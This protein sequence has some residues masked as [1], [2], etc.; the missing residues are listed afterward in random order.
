MTDPPT[1]SSVPAGRRHRWFVLGAIVAVLALAHPVVADELDGARAQKEAVRERAV[2]AAERLRTLNAKDDELRRGLEDLDQAIE[3][4]Q[5]KVDG[6]EQ[7][8]ASAQR[9][10]VK[11]QQDL[12]AT[13]L[14]LE[15]ARS[16]STDAVL[17]AYIGAASGV[18]SAA[19]WFDAADLGEAVQ[20]QQ[21]LG[22]VRGRLSQ[23]LDSLRVLSQDQDRA[24]RDAERA[25]LEVSQWRKEL[26][27]AQA[28]LDNNRAVQADLEEQLRGEIT[29]WAAKRDA[30]AASEA[31]IDEIIRRKTAEIAGRAVPRPSAAIQVASAGG[32]SSASRGNGT[33]SSSRSGY[34]WP[35]DGPLTSNF[36]YRR[37]PITGDVRLHAGLD[38]GA[39]YGAPIW[40]A[41]AGEVIFAGWNGGYGNC[42]MID[43]FDGV[44]TLYG[45]QSG[46]V[47][48]EGQSVARGTVIG[49]VGSTGAS[50]GAHLHFETRVD[51]TPSEPLDFL[52]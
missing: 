27:A 35:A 7:A 30:L 15:E 9:Q 21:L 4:Q 31:E 46:I 13:E 39:D 41:K 12:R 36:G 24:R 49:Y 40:A 6:A 20:K 34:I 47:V 25:Q 43:H 33:A 28:E 48:S 42:V 32:D 37:H 16:R 3:I 44:V 19:T 1:R 51:G 17:D 5:S 38:I 23:Q 26:K 18:G 29:D 14:R 8:L 50:T 45:H 52:P 22:A 2:E 11:A 10:T